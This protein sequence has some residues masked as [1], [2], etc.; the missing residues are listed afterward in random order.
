MCVMGRMGRRCDR[1][2]ETFD[3]FTLRKN[4]LCFRFLR[5]ICALRKAILIATPWMMSWGALLEQR[6]DPPSPQG[7]CQDSL[8]QQHATELRN[9]A[10][11]LEF[12]QFPAVVIEDITLT[13]C[14]RSVE[15]FVSIGLRRTGACPKELIHP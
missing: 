10:I 8:H 14:S 2:H 12:S 3:G 13:H 9:L 1:A 5:R 11:R 7:S 4:E 6:V 15:E